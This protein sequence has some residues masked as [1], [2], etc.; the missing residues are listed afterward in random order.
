MIRFIFP[1]V[2]YGIYLIYCPFSLAQSVEHVVRAAIDH[3]PAIDQAEAERRAAIEGV[4]QANAAYRP[5]ITLNA[6]ISSSERDARLRGSSDFSETSEPKSAAIRIDQALY[7]N[8]LRPLAKRRAI[9]G[10][11]TTRHQLLS[12]RH[13]IALEA[14]DALL[15]VH[16]ARRSVEREERRYALIEDQLSAERARYELQVGTLTDIS[17]A[18]ARLATAVA[19][20][21]LANAQLILAERD[22]E[23]LTGIRPA[24]LLPP[25]AEPYVP[26]D[27]DVAIRLARENLPELAVARSNFQASRLDVVSASKRYGPQVGLSL[28]ASSSRTPSPA[29]DRDDDV[30]ATISLSV[31]L[32]NGGRGS[33]ERRE[34]LARNRAA[35]AAIQQTDLNLQRRITSVWLSYESARNQIVALETRLSAAE[36]ALEGVRR[37]RDAGLWSITDILDAV[38]Q[39]IA[40]EQAIDEANNA[41]LSAAYELSISCGLINL[42]D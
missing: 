33:S 29:I 2:I 30:R 1:I 14:I 22:L 4:V 35:N 3:A 34:A 7:T 40:A 18:E 5:E 15:Q 6:S 21:S 26:L 13:G 17:Q 39:K 16:L 10:V 23:F 41:L 38:E 19:A 11:Q 20:K 8:G 36:I 24:K 32:F 42:V 12:V 25:V 28:E 31:P 9:A 37:G 27:L